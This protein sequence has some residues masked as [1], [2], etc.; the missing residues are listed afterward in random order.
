MTVYRNV[1][2]TVDSKIFKWTFYSS[3]KRWPLGP[4]VPGEVSVYYIYIYI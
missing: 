4:P 2:V 1:T 3:E